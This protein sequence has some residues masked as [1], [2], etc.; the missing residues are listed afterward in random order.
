MFINGAWQES[1]NRQHFELFDPATGE[2]I[3]QVPDGGQKDA[4]AAVESFKTWSKQTA[5]SKS[6]FLYQAHRLMMENIDHLAE[7]MTREMGKPIRASKNEVKYGAD[8]LL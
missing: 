5:Y 2:T 6:G 4:A 7:T 8:F 1:S 3:G